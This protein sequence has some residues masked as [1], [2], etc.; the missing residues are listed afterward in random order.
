MA[1]TRS[2]TARWRSLEGTGLD[3]V[4]LTPGEGRVVA[5][6][7][8]IGE[9]GG[10]PYGVFYRVDLDA[11]WRT[12]EVAIGTAEG[13]GLHLLSDGA[14]H[15]SNGVG[16][17]LAHLDGCVDVDLAGTPFTNTLPIMRHAWEQGERA[18]FRMLYIP[19]DSFVP[20]VDAQVYTCIE[21]GRRFLYEAADRSFSAEIA[22][23]ADGLVTDYPPLFTRML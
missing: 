10:T 8:V 3:H 23:D 20:S 19:F 1:L 12:R 22:V 14:G 5:R 17:H 6:G 7:T 18:E 4:T 16:E 13:Q 11:E 21:R 9:R 15:W 2:L